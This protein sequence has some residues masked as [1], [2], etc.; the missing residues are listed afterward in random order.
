MSEIEL[1][2]PDTSSLAYSGLSVDYIN[3]YERGYEAAADLVRQVVLLE[4]ERCAKVCEEK[5]FDKWAVETMGD[6][7]DELAA[8]IRKG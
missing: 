3:G 4:R 1:P 8:A 6:L 5:R 2:A 7:R